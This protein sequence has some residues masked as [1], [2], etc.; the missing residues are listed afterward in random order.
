MPPTGHIL[1]INTF[2]LFRFD[3]GSASSALVNLVNGLTI[4]QTN[5]PPAVQG[6]IDGGRSFNGTTQHFNGQ[7]HPTEATISAFLKSTYTFEIWLK[8]AALGA[9]YQIWQWSRS[10]SNPADVLFNLFL[11]PTG[12]INFNWNDGTTFQICNQTLGPALVAGVW[13][14]FAMTYVVNMS[15]QVAVRMFM[16]GVFVQGFTGLNNGISTS[17]FPEW[18]IGRA[19]PGGSAFYYNGMMD[20]TRLSN[21]ERSDAEIYDSWFRGTPQAGYLKAAENHPTDATKIRATFGEPVN[22][23]EA[24]VSGNWSVSGLTVSSVTVVNA[25]TDLQFDLTTT[26]APSRGTVYTVTV[27]NVH[28][29][30]DPTPNLIISP[31]DQI[32]FGYLS[33]NN[34]REDLVDFDLDLF[35]APL[36]LREFIGNIKVSTS[37]PVDTDPPIVTI[38]S[39][40]VGSSIARTIPIVFN[41]TDPGGDFRR[42]IIVATFASSSLK[43]VVH[44]GNTFGPKYVGSINTRTVITDGFQYTIL[45]DGGWPANL[46]LTPFAIDTAGN[47][48]V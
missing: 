45:R 8:P 44:D 39:P 46:V 27:S 43:E 9:T 35:Q 41:V 11:D 29:I 21:I 18:Y 36:L 20:D 3:E 40:A 30:V 32:K 42:I 48:N 5:S 7:A 38:I 47:E 1:D 28:D 10:P 2:Q 26:P 37:G 15:N 33:S 14:H 19:V 12:L 31:N 23:T 22:Q 13:R 25:N 17:A 34:I 6:R 16:D 24:E 4:A